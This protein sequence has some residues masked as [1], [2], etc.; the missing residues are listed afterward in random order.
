MFRTTSASIG[1]QR[2]SE[3]VVPLIV[4]MLVMALG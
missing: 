3:E 4:G 1:I 2:I